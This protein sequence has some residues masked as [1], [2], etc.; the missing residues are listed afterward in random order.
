MAED[1]K[2]MKKNSEVPSAF[3]DLAANEDKHIVDVLI[4]ERCPKLCESRSWPFVRPILYKLLGYTKARR[5]ADEVVK[6][7]GRES[8][9]RLAAQLSVS[10]S[11]EGL[12]RLP[13]SGRVIV[14]ANHPTGLADGIAVWDLL[15]QVRDDVVFFANADAIRVN[16]RFEDVIIPVEWVAE[17]RSPAKARETLKRA[18]AAFADE[19]CVVI[20]PSGR[21]AQRVEGRLRE[22]EWFSTVVGLARK[23]KA[24]IVPLNVSAENSWL[25][26]LFCRLNPELRDITLFNELLNKSGAPFE[27]TVGSLIPHERLAGDAL[28][29]TERLKDYVAYGLDANPSAVF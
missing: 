3:I 4:E 29:I 19:R 20:F 17:K 18:A 21:L 14:A 28:E 2:N 5:M 10:L 26:Y 15:K 1:T 11:H 23:R 12:E 7:N 9:D 25:Y 27:M 6:L 13:R 22:Q 8:F 16:P 24:P